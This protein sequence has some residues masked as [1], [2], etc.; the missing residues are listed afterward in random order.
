MK[1]FNLFNA[2][3]AHKVVEKVDRIRAER[4]C[5]E[6]ILVGPSFFLVTLNTY[7][8]GRACILL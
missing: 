1:S 5:Q 3:L 8:R 2:H 4:G 6:E 7:E